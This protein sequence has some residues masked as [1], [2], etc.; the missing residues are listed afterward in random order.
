MRT[1]KETGGPEALHPIHESSARERVEW[2]DRVGIDHCLVNPGGWWQMLEYLGDER[3][4]GA[5]RCN[6]FL[7]EQL[8]DEDG[9]LHVGGIR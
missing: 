4:D 9:R 8:S 7:T 5:R 2:M 6:D 3:A 1:A